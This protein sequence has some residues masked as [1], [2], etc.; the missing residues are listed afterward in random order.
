MKT[1]TVSSLRNDLFFLN[2]QNG[3]LDQ[4]KTMDN[5]QKRNICTEEICIVEALLYVLRKHNRF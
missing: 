3:D 1:E 5:V 4:D 2:K